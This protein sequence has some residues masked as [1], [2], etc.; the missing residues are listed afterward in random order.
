MKK[1]RVRE[2]RSKGP[3]CEEGSGTEMGVGR[4]LEEGELWRQA[5][6]CFSVLTWLLG[7]PLPVSP[8]QHCFLAQSGQEGN[9]R[10]SP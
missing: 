5:C 6:S 3:I 10:S 2:G 1:E 7:A 4:S 9:V 8:A